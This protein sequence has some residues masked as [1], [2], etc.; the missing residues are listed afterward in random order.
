M[1]TRITEYSVGDL[2]RLSGLTVRTLHHYHAVG[3]L[4][5]AH[6]AA[7]GYRVYRRA[8]LERLQEILVYRQAGLPLAAIA[9]A[10]AG[11]PDRAAR[12]RRHRQTLVDRAR[13]VSASLA[14][15]DR[16]LEQL[17]GDRI[18]TDQDLY[19]PFDP[20]RQQAYEDWLIA[21]YGPEMAEAI[22]A[23][24]AHLATAPDGM[25]ARM[26]ELKTIEADLVAAF[27]AGHDPAAALAR[28]RDWVAAMWGRDCPPQAYA[29]LADLYGAHA[30]FVARYEALA[31]K[32][33][34][35]LPQVMRDWAARQPG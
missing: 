7:N 14:T 6:V 15:L 1:S 20:A 32:F 12:L 10:L 27:T 23:A 21:T 30:D 28:H 19:A 16:I 9:E 35:W 3:L 24:R 4:P 33:S 18:V 25:A 5:P 13:Q 8:E 22:A 2:A 31:P 34:H 17:S 11:G 29:G 26:A